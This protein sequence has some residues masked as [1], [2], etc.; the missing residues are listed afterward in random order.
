MM[1]LNT[2]MSLA[3]LVISFIAAIGP[4]GWAIIRYYKD[5]RVEYARKAADTFYKALTKAN[6]MDIPLDSQELAYASLMLEAAIGHAEEIDRVKMAIIA[7]REKPT[8]EMSDKKA[9]TI[10]DLLAVIGE[11]VKC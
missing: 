8:D 2:G 9:K 4:T 1:D 7:Y 6:C 3:A 5:K 11:A 10:E